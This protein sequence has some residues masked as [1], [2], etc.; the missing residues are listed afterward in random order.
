MAKRFRLK[1]LINWTVQGPIVTRLIIHFLSYNIAT[2]FLL[3]LVYGIKTSLAAIAETP[4]SAEP[5]TFWQQAAPVVIC[6]CV[7]MPFMIWDLIKLTNRI[8]G[9]LFRFESIL[10]EFAKSGVL[11]KAA[12]REGDLLTDYQKQFNEFVESL[13]ALHPE[14]KPAPKGPDGALVTVPFRQTV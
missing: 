10:K 4:V 1:K 7:M 14:T 13:H 6:M 12:L 8:A 3:L 5:L 9:P 11:R 2:L